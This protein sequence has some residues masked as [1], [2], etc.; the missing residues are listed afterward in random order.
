MLRYSGEPTG[1]NSAILI[2][3]YTDLYSKIGNPLPE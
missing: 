3:I 2:W 1:T